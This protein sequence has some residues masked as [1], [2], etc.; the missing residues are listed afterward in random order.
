MLRRISARQM[1][2]WMAFEQIDPFGEKRAD[3]RA[4]S[5]VQIIANVNRD[6]KK[7]PKPYKIEEFLLKFERDARAPKRQTPQEQS[8]A[9]RQ[10]FEI[11]SLPMGEI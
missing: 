2:E 10:I 1:T 6:T 11:F 4:A 3:Y 5:I 8:R 9:M 7:R